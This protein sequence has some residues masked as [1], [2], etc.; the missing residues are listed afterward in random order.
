MDYFGKLAQ[1][2]GRLK[3]ASVGVVIE[4]RGDRHKAHYLAEGGTAA[5]WEGDYWKVYRHLPPDMALSA[6]EM[7]RLIEGSKANSKSRTRA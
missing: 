3:A 1:A 4:Q 7:A 6:D 2:N 5:T